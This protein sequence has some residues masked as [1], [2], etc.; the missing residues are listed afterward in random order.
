MVT[1]PKLECAS[2][3]SGNSVKLLHGQF[4]YSWQNLTDDK[5][6]NTSWGNIEVQQSGWENPLISIV[7]HIPVS[8]NLSGYM[9]WALWNQFVKQQYDGTTST[10]IYL[11]VYSGS[12]SENFR[13]YASSV[14]N[15]TGTFPIPIIIKSYSLSF[16]PG[17]SA[18]A[19]FWT[20]NAQLQE[21][22]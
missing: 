22:A 2:I 1:V 6:S 21:T 3:N 7:F 19:G 8:D 16:S 15:T 10:R 9:T 5:P 20:I 13:S 12:G 14:S 4:N 17:D 11:Y 18:D